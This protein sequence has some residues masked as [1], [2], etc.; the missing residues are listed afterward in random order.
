MALMDFRIEVAI[1]ELK[2][3]PNTGDSYILSTYK[4]AMLISSKYQFS[5]IMALTMSYRLLLL[6]AWI[7]VSFSFSYNSD[8]PLSI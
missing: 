4:R 2:N 3:M 8:K 5:N 7:S 6:V 1:L